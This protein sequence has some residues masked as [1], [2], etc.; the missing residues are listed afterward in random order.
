MVIVT[1]Q[2]AAPM[3]AGQPTPDLKF[4]QKFMPPN[5]KI[6]MSNPVL[7]PVATAQ[8]TPA[9][10]PVERLQDSLKPEQPLTSDMAPGGG[11]G[12]SSGSQMGAH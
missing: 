7:E 8:Q 4:P 5:S 1:P 6:P 10:M 2:L 12:S 3:P 11:Q 9:T